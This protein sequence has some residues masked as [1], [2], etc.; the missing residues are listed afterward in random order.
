MTPIR[1]LGSLAWLMMLARLQMILLTYVLRLYELRS[2]ARFEEPATADGRAYGEVIIASVL[3]VRGNALGANHF[4]IVALL[5]RLAA[6]LA[7]RKAPGAA[8]SQA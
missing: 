7:E 2:V 3:L 5:A 8:E 1:L 6:V 4:L